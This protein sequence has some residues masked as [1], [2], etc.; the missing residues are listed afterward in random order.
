MRLKCNKCKEMEHWNDEDD[1]PQD[2]AYRFKNSI[3]IKSR[4]YYKDFNRIDPENLYCSE[5]CFNND[6]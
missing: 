1:L 6:I 4:R 3:T 2:W 5:E